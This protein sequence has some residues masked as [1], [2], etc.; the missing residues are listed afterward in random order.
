MRIIYFI[1]QRV[2][3]LNRESYNIQIF[4]F[5]KNKIVKLSSQKY[6][7]NVIEACILESC[8][9]KDK[10]IDKLIEKNNVTTLICDQFGNYIIQKCLP[11]IE[12]KQFKSMIEQIKKAVKTLN[13]SNHGR[14][15]YENLLRNYREYFQDSKNYVCNK[16]KQKKNN[17]K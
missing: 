11:L 16:G 2:V 1:I 9:I 10:V 3:K 5:I 6:S 4:D 17:N 12:G 14:K 7:S 15:I 13:Q 8:N